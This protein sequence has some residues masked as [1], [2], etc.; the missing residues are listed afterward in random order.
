[1]KDVPDDVFERLP[2]D[3]ASQVDHDIYGLPKR[4]SSTRLS[5]TRSIGSPSSTE[6]TQVTMRC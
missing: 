1:M 2:K 6:K 4:S 5:Q 3:A